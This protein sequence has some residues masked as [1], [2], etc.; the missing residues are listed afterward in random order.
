MESPPVNTTLASS[1]LQGLPKCSGQKVS[2]HLVP[3]SPVAE[4]RRNVSW[5]Q[6]ILVMRNLPPGRNTSHPRQV[7]FFL[8]GFR[9]PLLPKACPLAELGAGTEANADGGRPG[10]FES[11][12]KARE[13]ESNCPLKLLDLFTLLFFP[14]SPSPLSSPC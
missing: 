14:S 10:Q 5:V 7:A 2:C 6:G 3:G 8:E 12:Q 1:F 13:G 9:L 4:P 11:P